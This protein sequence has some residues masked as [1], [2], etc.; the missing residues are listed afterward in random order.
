M[1]RASSSRRWVEVAGDD[2]RGP[3]GAG[4]PDREA[5]DR[6]AA[7]HQDRAAGHL[8]LEHRVDRVAHRIHD[9]A[10]LGG[11]AVELHDV[12]GRHRDV[13]GEG[14][15]AIHADDLGAP[16]EVAVAQA[17]LQTVSADDVAFGRDQVAHREQVAAAPLPC[18]A[19]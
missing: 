17:A 15:V 13:V 7:E 10:D 12:G 18:P 2:Q 14:A 3:G 6:A 9:G 8:R 16:A 1:S 5:P 11:D 4:H 19:G